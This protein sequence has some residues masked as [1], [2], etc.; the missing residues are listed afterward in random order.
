MEALVEETGLKCCIC[1]EG[2]KNHPK[3]ALGIY[4]FTKRAIIDEFENKARK[5]QVSHFLLT[6][7]TGNRTNLGLFDGQS[8]QRCSLRLSLFGYQVGFRLGKKTYFLV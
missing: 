2:Y 5:T 7:T 8:L 6:F 1:R 4:T 3:K